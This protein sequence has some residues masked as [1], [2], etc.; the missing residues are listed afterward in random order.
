MKLFFLLTITLR[1]ISSIAYAQQVAKCDMT[2]CLETSKKVG[3][4][5]Q[6]EMIDFLLTFGEECR[7]NVEYSEWSN[8]ILLELLE[9]QTELTVKTITLQSKRL[10]IMAILKNLEEPLHDRFDLPAIIA[11]VQKIKVNSDIKD[12]MISRLKIADAKRN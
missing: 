10:D 2:N 12:E 7:D 8:E 11:K 5:R 6:Q 1:L 4:L 9:K 3:H